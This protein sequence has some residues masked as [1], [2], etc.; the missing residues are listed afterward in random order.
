VLHDLRFA[1]RLLVKHPLFSLGTI[2]VLALGIGATTAMFSVVDATLL[3]P[4]PYHEPQRLVRLFERSPAGRRVNASFP[5]VHDWAEL[6]RTFDGIAGI[7]TGG[8]AALTDRTDALPV[9]V[10]TQMV[11]ASFFD[12]LGVAPTAGRTFGVA[13][14]T[15]SPVVM[16]SGRL[17]RSRFNADPALVG[18]PIH[19]NGGPAL[20][21]IGVMPD[22]FELLAPADA[23]TLVPPSLAGLTPANR[24]IHFLDVVA[25]LKPDASIDAARDD[26]ARVARGIAEQAPDTNRNWSVDI[27]PLQRALVSEDLRRTTLALTAAVAFILLM[28]CANVANLMLSRGAGRAREIAV[29]A[30]LGGSPL[31]IV[32]QLTVESA[33]LAGLG[34][35]AGVGVAAAAIAA[36]PAVMP[37]GTIPTGFVITMNAR[38]IACAALLMVVAACLTGALPAWKTIG[39]SLVD[40]LAAG[41]R[42]AVGRSRIRSALAV[43]QIAAAVVLLVGAALFI[44]TITALGAVDAGFHADHVM[45]MAVPLPF[46]R[47]GSPARTLAFYEELEARA[48][49]LPGVAQAAVIAGDLPLD[50]NT[51]VQTFDVAGQANPDPA[52]RPAAHFQMVTPHYFDALG[53]P[54][55][56]GR[57]FSDRDRASGVP[58]CLVNEA[59]AARYLA[60]RDPLSASVIVNS[61]T[62]RPSDSVSVARRIVGVVGQVRLRPGEREPFPEIYVPLAQ[63]P[64]NSGK[65]IVRAA[66]DRESSSVASTVREVVAGLDR[67]LAVSRVRTMEEVAGE[68]TAT[69]RFRAQLTGVLAALAGVIAAVGLFSVLAFSVRQRA[70]ELGIRMALGARPADIVR[71][72]LSDGLVLA[73]I[74]VAIGMAASALLAQFVAS[75]LFGVT[76]I[77]PLAYASAGG[78]VALLAVAASVVPAWTATRRAAGWRGFAR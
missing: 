68:A 21:V 74:G 28:A 13:D 77:D 11:T 59:F 19:L 46:A 57:P 31:R 40:G 1:L 34:G 15:G 65:L 61:L 16:I 53:I 36:A 37:A 75:L 23:W 17:W 30:A 67:N 50:G 29:R 72:V 39:V 3:R 26:L 71:L 70:A 25:R 9:T 45:T 63:N 24:R 48:S 66:D 47:Y 12:V 10:L 5:T 8:E 35:V 69:P 56:R 41:S 49:S 42:V 6:T 38:L 14:A 4:L 43:L 78:A 54:L 18:A 44:R 22:G 62:A 51:M 58:V 73:G 60:G 32:R 64:W 27:E 20:T 52:Q 55:V 7:G 33:L 76:G 2:V